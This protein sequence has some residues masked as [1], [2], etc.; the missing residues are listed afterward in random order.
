MRN[1]CPSSKFII[2]THLE[3]YNLVYDGNSNEWGCPIANIVELN[4]SRVYGKLFGINKDNLA[5]LDFYQGYPN[6]CNR[7]VLRVCEDNAIIYYREHEKERCPREEYRRL[8]VR[9]ALDICVPE[10]YILKNIYD[11]K[12]RNLDKADASMM[13][14]VVYFYLNNNLEDIVF[15]PSFYLSKK[16]KF[17]SMKN[18]KKLI[19]FS[20]PYLINSYN[21]YLSGYD[22]EKNLRCQNKKVSFKNFYPK[23]HIKIQDGRFFSTISHIETIYV[24]EN[25]KSI[26]WELNCLEDI[27]DR[28][29]AFKRHTYEGAI[30]YYKRNDLFKFNYVTD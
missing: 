20:F 28:S 23:K 6:K 26:I 29:G 21:F 18:N 12:A 24:S 10:E 1:V 15:K 14:H 3:N 17:I 2:E 4:G 27:E 30:I 11:Q 16:D 22:N 8:L 9:E 5:A 7:K 19:H 25:A 13:K